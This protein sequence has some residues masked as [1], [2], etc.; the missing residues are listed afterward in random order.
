MAYQFQTFEYPLY[1]LKLQ[2]FPFLTCLNTR[3]DLMRKRKLV[4]LL[5][6]SSWC[7]VTVSIFWLFLTVPRVGLQ[8]VIEAFPDQTHLRLLMKKY[9]FDCFYNISQHGWPSELTK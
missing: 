4:A 5:Q 9:Y 6:L 8:Y 3:E 1:T 2:I 7:L